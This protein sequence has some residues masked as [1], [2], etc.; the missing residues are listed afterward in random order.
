M[1]ATTLGQA[2][3]QLPADQGTITTLLNQAAAS[4]VHQLLSAAPAGFRFSPEQLQPVLKAAVAARNPAAVAVI[5]AAGAS[6]LWKAALVKEQIEAA[7]YKGF[8]SCFKLLVEAAVEAELGEL[9]SAAGREA[10]A[11]AA[12]EVGK[13]EQL[14]AMVVLKH[15][16]KTAAR[17]TLQL[18]VTAWVLGKGLQVGGWT[19]DDMAPAI[20]ACIWSGRSRQLKQ[21][22][23]DC[24]IAWQHSELKRHMQLAAARGKHSVALLQQ[25]FAAAAAAEAPWTDEEICEV[26]AEATGSYYECP[27]AV[28]FL[29]N[30]PV[31]GWKNAW[32]VAALERTVQHADSSKPV[33][34]GLVL[35]AA[36]G[37]WTAEQLRKTL[38]LAVQCFDV[39]CLQIILKVKDVPWAAADIEPAVATAVSHPDRS[40][41]LQQLLKIRLVPS[42][43]G[44]EV[45]GFAAAAIRCNFNAGL[46]MM[47]GLP[48]AALELTAGQ[49]K[50]LLVQLLQWHSSQLL[51][52]LQRGSVC[53][54][55]P[56]QDFEGNFATRSASFRMLLALPNAV[57][58]AQDLAELLAVAAAAGDK[59]MATSLIEQQG[60]Q[61][62][63]Q[64]LLPAIRAALTAER[65]DLLPLLLAAY[66]G[67]PV[68]AADLLPVLHSVCNCGKVEGF[69][70]LQLLLSKASV[71]FSPQDWLAALAVA[72]GLYRD[73]LVSYLLS[74][75]F[76]G[77]GWTSAELVGVVLLAF[78][79]FSCPSPASVEA[80][81]QLL[82]YPE[83][84]WQGVDFSAPA[85]AAL[86]NCQWGQVKLMLEVQEAGRG[87]FFDIEAFLGAFLQKDGWVGHV[88]KLLEVKRWS[89]EE[90]WEVLE[91]AVGEQQWE[92]VGQVVSHVTEGTKRRGW[93]AKKMAPVLTAAAAS[94]AA[95]VVVCLLGA[96]GV[97]VSA[98]ALG[99]ALQAA[100]D[101]KHWP[102]VQL[103]LEV[104]GAG[105]TGWGLRELLVTLMHPKCGKQLKMLLSVPGVVWEGEVLQAAADTGITLRSWSGLEGLVSAEIVKW[106]AR[107]LQ[108]LLLDAL[109]RDRRGLA[110]KI[111]AKGVVDFTDDTVAT[112]ALA[113]AATSAAAK[114][115]QTKLLRLLLEGFNGRSAAAF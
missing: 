50:G 71:E 16:L 35:G 64:E 66:H 97:D 96:P 51:H 114:R 5:L 11:G 40:N 42:W 99:G 4:C 86:R 73:E 37:P 76:K 80:V 77:A 72:V 38:R 98:A 55:Y 70:K 93:K 63:L 9:Q 24:G 82:A 111:L 56:L 91:A 59:T 20:T 39:A 103:L 106:D 28:V 32:M 3:Q 14:A 92:V 75:P 26:L 36:K 81:Q 107:G 74:G 1:V 65:W 30:K 22:L 95:E 21:L 6:T 58:Q 29:L 17:N 110:K 33:K 41:Q 27:D 61:W 108:R 44:P 87:T 19:A 83:E 112:A 84:G 2:L 47:L 78:R 12:G 31:L 18:S 90:L 94:G 48:A 57:W 53:I 43:T 13:A 109:R 54:W 79:K 115:G 25:L 8:S 113:A 23:V 7:A 68:A 89:G 46:E 88:P 15:A 45:E 49:I 52:L 10:A 101:G 62:Q 34:L 104:E 60:V 100:V 105:W 102:V 69:K 85:D 67:E